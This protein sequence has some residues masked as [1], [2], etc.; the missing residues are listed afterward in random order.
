MK[1]LKISA[2]S[3][4]IIVFAALVAFADLSFEQKT[5]TS[6]MMGQPGQTFTQKVWISKNLMCM[7]NS[8]MGQKMIFDTA[9]NKL[10][11]INLKQKTYSEVTPEQY[12]QMTG[13][14]MAMMGQKGMM[15]FTLQKTGRTKT[16]G[17]WNCYEVVMATTGGMD[18]KLEMW[19]TDDIKYDKANYDK[20]TEIFASSFFTEKAMQE[21]KKID[22]FPVYN[23]MHMTMGQMKMESTTE[24]TN[25]SY[26]PIPKDVFAVPAGFTKTEFNMQQM[27]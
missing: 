9:A 21:W 12:K 3:F 14:M 24:V 20:Y 2:L 16:I 5:T 22:G 10:I 13:G 27:P 11:I 18:V 25:V 6:G 23:T 8:A 15:E 7:D 4:L 26:S 19:V 17:S 1:L